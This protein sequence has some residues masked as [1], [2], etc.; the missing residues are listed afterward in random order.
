MVLCFLEN[1]NATCK[2]TYPKPV[3]DTFTAFH[4]LKD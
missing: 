1:A 3:I 2:P 4:F